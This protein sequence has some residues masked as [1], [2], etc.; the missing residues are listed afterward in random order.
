MRSIYLKKIISTLLISQ[1]MIIIN[2]N[3]LNAEEIFSDIYGVPEII[4]I[5][6]LKIDGEYISL[7]NTISFNENQICVD[8]EIG[9][10]NCAKSAMIKL[11][12]LIGNKIIYCYM[13]KW[14]EN[15]KKES[16]CVTE[17]NINISIEMIK[18]GWSLVK[19]FDRDIN[20][21]PIECSVS[22]CNSISE[23]YFQAEKMAA[24]FKMGVWNS[25][26]DL[27][28]LHKLRK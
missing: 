2:S 14:D 15:G 4:D 17:D 6:T 12:E 19:W 5:N 8:K 3:I 27:P 26:F 9:E 23:E 1:L 24:K 18:S 22:T 11:E 20:K 10:Y 16:L 28:W 25:Q 21:K 13:I 7:I